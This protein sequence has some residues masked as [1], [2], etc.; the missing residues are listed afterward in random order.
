MS[1][2]D[3]YESHDGILLLD[4]QANLLEPLKTRITV[5]LIP[6]KNAPKPAQRLNPV[7]D[8]NE[9]RYVMVTQ[10]MASIPT[11]ELKTFVINLSSQHDMIVNALDMVFQGY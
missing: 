10:F 1:R 7:F 9:Q 5:P 3:V 4:V 6:Y 11:S 2:Y 8:I